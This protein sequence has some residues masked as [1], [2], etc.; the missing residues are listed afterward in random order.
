[1]GE[2][3]R[4]G[5]SAGYDYGE[6]RWGQARHCSDDF[7]LEKKSDEEVGEMGLVWVKSTMEI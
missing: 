7:V 6:W 5:T 4:G 3:E 1:M 2:E